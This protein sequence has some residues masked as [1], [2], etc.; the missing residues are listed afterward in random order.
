MAE[1]NYSAE[2]GTALYELAKES[3]CSKSVLSDFRQAVSLFKDNPDFVKMLS[4]PA[5]NP[6]ERSAC[7]DNTFGSGIQPYLLNF[8]KLL[9]EKRRFGSVYDCLKV[10]EKLY[11]SDNGILAV[12]AVSAVKLSEKQADALREK[13][14]LKTGR[15]ILLNL[16]TDESCIGGIRLEY[17]GKRYDASVRGRLSDMLSRLKNPEI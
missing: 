16:K 15:E 2:Y 4:S 14:R 8:F 6:S 9:A 3:D 7:L 17:D 5:L 10:Y 1:R 12:T 13:L 11:C